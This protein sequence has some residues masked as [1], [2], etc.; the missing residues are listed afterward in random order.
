MPPQSKVLTD[1]Y[2]ITTN[3][4]DKQTISFSPQN[5]E[6]FY[7]NDVLISTDTGQASKSDQDVSAHWLIID[8][9]LSL[10]SNLFDWSKFSTEKTFGTV[11][12]Y[13]EF[14]VTKDSIGYELDS[15]ETLYVAFEWDD[16]SNATIHT[17]VTLRQLI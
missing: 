14:R 7:V 3:Y 13:Y 2:N 9:S 8:N 12:P 4:S 11:T 16:I 17:E 15:E 5:G 10:P 1:T 6:L